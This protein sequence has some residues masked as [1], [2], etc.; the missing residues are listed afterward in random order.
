MKNLKYLILFAFVFMVWNCEEMVFIEEM[1]ESDYLLS[2]VNAE[3]LEGLILGTYEPLARSRGRLWESHYG[4]YLELMGEYTLS[5]N[6][7]FNRFATY[8]FDAV[9]PNIVNAWTTFYEAIGRANFL[10]QSVEENTNLSADVRD[11][12]IAEGRFIR[13]LVY[14]Q[15]VRAWGEVPLRLAP[16]SNTDEIGQPLASIDEIYAQIIADLQFAENALPETVPA[17]NVG[18]ATKG[19]AITMLADVYLTLGDYQNAHSKALEVINNKDAFGY[20][21][22]PSFDVLYSATSPTNP[23][24]VFSIKF[25]QIR[26][27]GNFLTAYAHDARAAAAGLAA[28]GLRFYSVFENVPLIRDWDTQ[29]LRRELNLYDTITIDGECVPAEIPL[30]GDYFLGKYID[31]DAP[32]ET[33]AGNDFYIYRY[34]DVLLIFAETENQLNGPTT[35]AYDA[36]N[37]VRRRGYGVDINTPSE[38]ADLPQDLSQTEFDDL[39]FQE[40]GYEFFFECKRW[41]DMKRTDRWERIADESPIKPVPTQGEFW[42]IPNVE[43]A[44]NPDIN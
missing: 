44:N 32:E 8:N 30:D 28:R 33:A 11:R 23:E 36:I 15:L 7:G 5:R 9:E 35:G 31:P 24:D 40:R 42:P 37:Q 20:G 29:D 10:I 3:T 38:L 26:A 18:R 12:A 13:A 27:Q 41:F 25:A 14:Y 16:V 34:A 19:A 22:E 21:L 17:A 2:G 39:I 43:I 1:P 6:G 4:S